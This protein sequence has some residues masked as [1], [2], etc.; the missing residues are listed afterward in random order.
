MKLEWLS[1]G[2]EPNIAELQ[3][4]RAKCSLAH[5]RKSKTCEVMVYVLFLHS[6][7]LSFKVCRPVVY[8]PSIPSFSK[9]TGPIKDK[10]AYTGTRAIRRQIPPS[11]PKWEITKITNRQDTT[12]TNGQPS[13]NPFPKRWSLSNPNRTKSKMTN[14]RYITKR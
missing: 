2:V 4:V 5:R 11:K 9:T 3:S 7:S 10:K 12:K 1:G 13:G 6:S 14:I 8:T